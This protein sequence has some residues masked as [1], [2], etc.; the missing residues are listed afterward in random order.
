[1]DFDKTLNRIY[2]SAVLAVSAA[3]FV[4]PSCTRWDEDDDSRCLPSTKMVDAVISFN[5]S[6]SDE[7]YKEI[8]YSAPD[9][10]SRSVASPEGYRVRYMAAAYDS[11]GRKV[12]HQFSDSPEFEMTV[13]SGRI[14]IYGWAEYVPSE[15]RADK[16]YWYFTDEPAEMLLREKYKYIGGENAKR[17][18]GG[19]LV[20]TLRPTEKPHFN[21]ELTPLVGRYR[22]IPNDD[23]KDYTVGSIRVSYTKGMWG[24]VNLLLDKPVVRWSGVAFSPSVLPWL[25]APLAH[26]N[27]FVAPGEGENVTV[28]VTVLDNEGKIRARIPRIDI[29]VKRGHVT[30]VVGDFYN[31]LL[32]EE[33]DDPDNPDNPDNPTPPGGGIGIDP[34]FDHTITIIVD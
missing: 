29:P 20:Y 7:L 18:Y 27:V 17:A 25:G 12:A 32:P 8:V 34:S 2:K 30:D 10:L 33:P 21:I 1:M 26:D 15:N 19:S 9:S 23:P 4:L 24:G 13:P 6:E 28:M 16:D 5:I 14:S 31:T 22:I 3:L 11:R